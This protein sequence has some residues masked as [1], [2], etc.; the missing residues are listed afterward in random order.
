MAAMIEAKD[1]KAILGCDDETL[2]GHINRGAIRA[3][4]TNGK[5]MLNAEDV[6]K[7]TLNEDDEDGTIVLTGDSD[8]LQIDLGSVVDDT[9]ATMV[10]DKKRASTAT[11]TRSD[12]LTFG[13]ELEVI[14]FDQPEPTKAKPAASAAPSSLEMSFTDQNTAVMSSIDQ[15]ALG[16][17]APIEYNTGSN[18]GP[19]TTRADSSRRSVRSNRVRAEAP[20]IHWGWPLC[21]AG[22][23][24]ILGLLVL[25]YHLMSAW[26]IGEERD[27]RGDMKRGVDD[28]F[29]TSLASSV[30]G[31]SVEPDPAQF[32]RMNGE[33]DFQDLKD[34]DLQAEWRYLKY[35]GEFKDVNAQERAKTFLIRK[36][37]DDGS[38]AISEGDKKTYAIVEVKTGEISDFVV[39]LGFGK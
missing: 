31:F 9:S 30:S 28:T 17:T 37:S 3:Q 13:D 35:R 26:P 16:T 33:A 24:L 22:S 38:K 19:S 14:S 27:S 12:Q 21:M 8:N 7:L 20:A 6:Q 11:A 23:T 29:F 34:V 36:I 15:T 18:E 25:P 4:R 1:A 39:D 10:T 5:M 32:R 2:N